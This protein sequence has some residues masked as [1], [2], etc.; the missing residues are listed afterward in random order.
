MDMSPH[1]ITTLFQQLRLPSDDSEIDGF[2]DQHI[3][4]RGTR[5]VEA[6]FWTVSQAAFLTEALEDDSDWAEIVDQLDVRLRR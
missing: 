5:L 4:E 6:E 1:N 2:C 3:L